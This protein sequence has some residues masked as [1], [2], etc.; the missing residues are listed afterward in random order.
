[1]NDEQKSI[2]IDGQEFE[3]IK[4]TRLRD[5]MVI[6]SGDV[7]G[8]LGPKDVTLDEQVH[9][10]SLHERGFPVPEVLSSGSYGDDEWFFLETSLGSQTFHEIFTDEYQ[11]QGKVSDESFGKYIHVIEEY[12]R[13]Q[14]A[15]DNRTS[16]SA[17][18]FI[19]ELI[20]ENLVLPQYEYFGFSRDRYHEVI[21]KVE[22]RLRG[23]PMGIL[24]FD[25]NP[26]NVLEGGLIDFELV[27]YGPI[28]FDSFISARWATA[29]FTDYP[30]RHPVS[31]RLSEEQVLRNDTLIDD[32]M[33]AAGLVSPKKYMQEFLVLKSAWGC[34]SF[35]PISDDLPDDKIAFARFRV[36]ILEHCIDKYL[37]DELIDYRTLASLPG[38]EIST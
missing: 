6:K 13:A 15:P 14:V 9:T 5:G 22:D 37:G 30:S 19:S 1:M 38:G 16:V 24:Q 3:I 4:P 25:L 32:V 10:K 18:D 26:Y 12:V 29:W 34:R 33:N 36:N 21:S 23:A 27:G 31:Y 35:T 11:S 28:G 2:Q 20:P 17:T 8:R 7:Y